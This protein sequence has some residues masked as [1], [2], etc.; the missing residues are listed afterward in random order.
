MDAIVFGVIRNELHNN[1]CFFQAK[2]MHWNSSIVAMYTR[3]YTIDR[4]VGSDIFIPLQANG[5]QE[6]VCLATDV[7]ALMVEEC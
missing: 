7:Y 6:E 2:R 5:V 1:L 4:E 3:K